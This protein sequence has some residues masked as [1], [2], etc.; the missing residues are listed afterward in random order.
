M[1]NKPLIFKSTVRENMGP[2][3]KMSSPYLTHKINTT[4]IP[5]HV[6]LIS[7]VKP[8]SSKPFKSCKYSIKSKY[9]SSRLQLKIRFDYPL[10]FTIIDKSFHNPTSSTVQRKMLRTR[11]PKTINL[12][13]FT[14]SRGC[15]WQRGGSGV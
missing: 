2:L 6:Y 7:K 15:L 5:I 9:Q 11:G 14:T 3:I 8:I 4:F 13:Y 1:L 12:C 10:K